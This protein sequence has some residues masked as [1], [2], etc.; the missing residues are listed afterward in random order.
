MK[1]LQLGREECRTLRKMGIH[2]PHACTRMRA[3]GVLRLS[4]G[5]TLQQVADEFDVH[6]NSVEHW[7]QRWGQFGLVGLHEG[8]HSGRPPTLSA[9]QHALR[10]LTKDKGGSSKALLHEWR[11]QQGQS[12]LSRSS[13]KRHLK[14]MGFRYKCCRLSLKDKRDDDAFAHAKGAM[15]SLQAM[16]LAGQCELLYFDE[17]GFSPNPPLQYGWMRMGQTRCAESGSHQQR[18]NVLGALGYDHKLVWRAQA[19]RTVRE[20]VMAFFDQIA[21]QPH[22]A[23]CIVVLDNA[24]IHKG[25][26]IEENVGNGSRAYICITCRRTARGGRLRPCD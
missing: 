6:L 12:P 11:E 25:E 4:Q 10:D 20:D 16:A 24:R 26:V 8:R 18:V 3:Q 2:H 9:Q 23:P 19:K 22:P 13:L 17:S 14:R 5:L 15:A 1:R 21:E 7:K